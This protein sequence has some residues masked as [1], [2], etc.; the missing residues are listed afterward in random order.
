MTT[1]VEVSTKPAPATKATGGGKPAEHADAGQQ[2]AADQH[3]RD[4][5]AEDLACAGS[6]AATAASRAR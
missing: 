5:E 2:G 3:L 6:T 1:A 4:A